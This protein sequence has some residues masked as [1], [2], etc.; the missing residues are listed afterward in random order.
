MGRLYTKMKIFHFKDKLASLPRDQEA[1]L[2]PVHIRIKPTNV[3]NHN[4]TYCAYRA[5]DLQLGKDMDVRASIPKEK[6]LAT[7]DDII[8]MGVKAVTFSGGGEPFC[9][10]HLAEVARKLADSP[11]QFASLTNGSRLCGEA[12]EIFAHHA[13]W[14]R[15][16]MDGWDSKSYAEYRK[17]SE[18][19]FGKVVENM[20][21]F[22]AMG[23][24]C[25][26]GLSFIVDRKNAAHVYDFLSMMRDVGVDSVKVSPCIT[27][28]E[29]AENNLY[30][31]P[32]F[33]QVK[34]DVA[35]AI[36]DLG[37]NDF[38]IYDSYHELDEKFAK[39]YT[40]CPYLQIL[41][42]IGADCNVY[43]CQDKAYNLEEGAIGSI[44]EQGFA[45][46]WFSSKEKFFSINPSRHCNHHCV[47]NT[48][49]NLILEYLEA[50]PHHLGFV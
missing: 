38:Q 18:G 7:I 43:S 5:S 3:C 8:A 50:D 39:T 27:S 46:F 14:V 11:V 21:S 26:L 25:Y 34:E 33:N 4:C 12:A 19:E 13:R 49:N 9:Y 45:D 23:G 41:P 16:S 37:G 20:R 35:R 15:V 48:K 47:A 29:G 6:I 22:K 24:K 30:H 17:V 42:V 28:N 31:T 1:V 32:I 36:S 44:K 10:P 2:P 40:W